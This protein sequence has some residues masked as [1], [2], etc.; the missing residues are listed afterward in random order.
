MFLVNPPFIS[1]PVSALTLI[2]LLKLTKSTVIEELK[3]P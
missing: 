2:Q 1:M 3:L